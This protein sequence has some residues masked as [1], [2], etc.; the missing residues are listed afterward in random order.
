VITHKFPGDAEFAGHLAALGHD[1]YYYADGIIE[2]RKPITNRYT[3]HHIAAFIISYCRIQVMSA[4]MQFKPENIA[5][6]WCDQIYYTGEKPVLPAIFCDKPVKECISSTQ[7][8]S[9][10]KVFSFSPL[11]RGIVG[12]TALLGQ[13]GTGKTTT[14]GWDKGFN[15]ILYVAPTHVLLE[16]KRI[17]FPHFKTATKCKVLGI[18]CTSYKDSLLTPPVLFF[19]EATQSSAEEIEQVRTMYPDSLILIAGDIDAEGRN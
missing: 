13:G 4:M 2:V 14:I 18:G 5:R 11:C 19:D 6:V 3:A 12:N 7:W 8:F 1:T 15:T 17:E 10:V 9:E 16:D